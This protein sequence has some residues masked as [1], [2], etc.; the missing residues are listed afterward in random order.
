MNIDSDLYKERSCAKCL[1][2]AFDLFFTN[3]MSIVR[4]TWMYAV[5]FSVVLA[6]YAIY[7]APTADDPQFVSKA[8]LFI[9]VSVLVLIA[10]FIAF[11]LF[12]GQVFHLRNEQPRR[13]CML[14]SL[15]VGLLNI[16]QFIVV[17]AIATAIVLQ[18]GGLLQQQSLPRLFIVIVLALL[19]I[20]VVAACVPFAY[21]T[22]KYMEELDFRFRQL[23][24]SAYRQGW[25]YWGFLVINFIVIGL[26]EAVVNLLAVTPL[27]VLILA[28]GNNNFGLTLGD[29]DGLPGSFAVLMFITTLVYCLVLLYTLI[30]QIFV[31]T[32]AYGHVEANLQIR[33]QMKADA[34]NLATTN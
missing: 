30:W 13:V 29:E 9:G 31:Q 16:A 4:K 28:K 11:H 17:G 23:F 1:H 22:I 10:A 15:K 27:V 8:W 26:I 21:T 5:A 33:Q 20:L 6:L 2:S 18:A 12:V 14:R 32:Y 7:D 34:Q 19:L 24:G 25:R 3:I